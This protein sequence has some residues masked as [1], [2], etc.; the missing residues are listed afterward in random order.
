[1]FTAEHWADIFMQLGVIILQFLSEQE[2]S[3]QKLTLY[4]YVGIVFSY[5]TLQG[6][7]FASLL[8]SHSVSFL[9]SFIPNCIIRFAGHWLL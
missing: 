7:L 5:F 6:M 8:P 9:H 2:Q 4:T 1:M 3:A